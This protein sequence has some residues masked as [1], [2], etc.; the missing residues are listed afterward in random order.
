MNNNLIINPEYESIV[1]PISLPEYEELK[2]SIKDKGLHLPIFVNPNK[3]ILDGHN[4]YRI[5][6]ELGIEPKFE[7]KTFK[8][9]FDEKDFVIEINIKRRQLNPFQL[10]QL[11]YKLE[12][13]EKERAKERQST[14]NNKETASAQLS[15]SEEVGRTRDIVSKKVGISRG[16]Y[17]RA[18]KIIEQGSDKLKENVNKGK[19]SINYAYKQ[20]KRQESHKNIPALPEGQFSIIL[21][22]PPWSYDINTRGSPDDHYD[23]MTNEDIYNLKVPAADDAILFLWATA[24]K[25]QEALNT[26]KSWG[27]K[28]KTHAIWIKD[29]IG[30]GYY[31][32]GQHELLLI[33]EKG[34]MPIPEEKNRPPSI[35]HAIRGDH[36]KKPGLVYEMIESMYPNRS[37]IELFARQNTRTNWKSWGNEINQ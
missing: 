19:T 25:L 9:R 30:T 17:E 15:T 16:T 35:F 32:R 2:N 8:D 37:Y 36:S 23:V 18:K 1:P 34:D 33:G 12:D 5:C 26:L 24:P 3:V 31:F 28:Y 4:R 7:I 6:Q 14:L 21:A 13:N 29:K 20:I 11:A 27:F 22:D 10:A